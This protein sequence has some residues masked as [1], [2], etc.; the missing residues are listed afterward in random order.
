MASTSPHASVLRRALR[1]NDEIHALFGKLGSEEHPRGRLLSAY[2]QARNAISGNVDNP[3][4]LAAI[5]AQLHAEVERAVIDILALAG[6][7]GTGQALGDLRAYD[8]PE[9]TQRS[10]T[11]E[12]QGLRA[13]LAVL[14][15]QITGVQALASQTGD[16]ALIIGDANRVGVLTPGP[17]KSEAARWTTAAALASY[18]LSVNGSLRQASQE[19]QY[20]KQAIAA[21]DE[22]TT[23]TCLRVNGQTQQIGDK[24]KLTGTPRFADEL[25]APP[26]HEYC[27]TAQALVHVEDAEDE[28]TQE[29][30]GASQAELKAREDGSRQVIHPAFS[31]S[32]R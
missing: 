21:I 32:G 10:L 6:E 7:L 29:I 19:D 31:F 16:E 15:G 5:L 9:I 27:R 30:R 20:L 25:D 18:W 1:T 2:R 22:R 17:V 12:Q 8:L 24:F 28:L 14:E 26:F 4:A 23:E 11:T 13:T 3:T